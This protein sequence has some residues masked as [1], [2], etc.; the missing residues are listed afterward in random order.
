MSHSLRGVLVAAATALAVA[1]VALS[2]LIR[3]THAHANG[4]PTLVR[5]SYLEGLK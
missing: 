5:L 4:V 3:V 1:V 2:P